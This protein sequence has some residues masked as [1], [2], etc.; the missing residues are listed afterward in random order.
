MDAMDLIIP[1]LGNGV[2]N[3]ITRYVDNFSPALQPDFKAFITNIDDRGYSFDEAMY[4]LADSLGHIFKDFAQKAI[5]YEAAGEQ[6][7]LE[8][9]TDLVETNRLR[10]ELRMENEVIFSSL[11]ASFAISTLIVAVYGGVQI[12]TDEFFYNFFF[13]NDWGKVLFI[14]MFIIVFGVLS[15]ITTLKSKVL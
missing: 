9:F 10:R 8:I 11:T 4:I 2:K 12:A 15:Y 6:D 5:F 1:E 14:C 13:G 3:A 7:M